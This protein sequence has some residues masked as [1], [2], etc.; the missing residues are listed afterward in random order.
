MKQ[1]LCTQ[2]MQELNKICSINKHLLS[3]SCVLITMLGAPV[4]RKIWSLP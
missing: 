2:L 1:Q 3:M 4:N